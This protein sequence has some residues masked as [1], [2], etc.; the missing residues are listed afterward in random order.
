MR[1]YFLTKKKHDWKKEYGHR[2]TAICLCLCMAR[3]MNWQ[4]N[5]DVDERCL[6]AP[7]KQANLLDAKQFENDGSDMKKKKI[8]HSEMKDTKDDCACVQLS[9][10]HSHGRASCCIWMSATY[11]NPNDIAFSCS[12]P[13]DFLKL[14]LVSE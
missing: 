7:R 14:I 9:S 2:M 8:K 12:V 10:S 13:S 3:G 5:G 6:L 4:G 1:T 11:E